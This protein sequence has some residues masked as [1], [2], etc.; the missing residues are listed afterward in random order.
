MDTHR[1]GHCHVGWEVD[2][3]V[4]AVVVDDYWVVSAF[5]CFL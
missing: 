1:H 5:A 2:L 4:A 3:L